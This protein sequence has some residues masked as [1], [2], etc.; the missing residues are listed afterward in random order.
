MTQIRSALNEP[1]PEFGGHGL[2][3]PQHHL[4]A[5]VLGIAGT[6]ANVKPVDEQCIADVRAIVGALETAVPHQHMKTV[7][8]P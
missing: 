5:L 2:E 4:I 1:N 8:T 6:L 3:A 7:N